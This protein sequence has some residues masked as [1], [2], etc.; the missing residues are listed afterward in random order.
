[1]IGSLGAELLK[2]RTTRASIGLVL[3]LIAVGGIAG[4]GTVGTAPRRRLE[5]TDFDGELALAAGIAPLFA[6]LF[7]VLV[8][9]TEF[10]HATATPTFLTTPVREVVIAAK[11]LAAASAGVA[12]GLLS[13]AAVYAVALPWLAARGSS[14]AVFGGEAVPRIVGML[15]VAAAW[16]ALGVGLG[17]LVRNQVGAVVAALLWFLMA[18]PLVG[19]L[20]DEVAPYLP[21]AAADAL[22]G[23]EDPDRLSQLGGLAVSVAY[24]AGAC[25]LGTL[26]VGRIDIT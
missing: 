4:A 23:S 22:S 17:A 9:T 2:L 1:V 26:A 11:T 7:G 24:A 14:L 25:V 21:G 15:G 10:R 8:V 13:L 3:A 6:L 19:F 18:E 12:L 20:L 16:G 5:T